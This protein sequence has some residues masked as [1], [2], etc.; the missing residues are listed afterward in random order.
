MKLLAGFTGD[1][2]GREFGAFLLGNLV[3]VVLDK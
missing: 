2:L 1:A 3:V